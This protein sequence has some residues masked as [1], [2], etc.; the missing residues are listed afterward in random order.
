MDNTNFNHGE[1]TIGFLFVYPL[2]ITKVF[3]LPFQ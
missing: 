3:V 2:C 1:H